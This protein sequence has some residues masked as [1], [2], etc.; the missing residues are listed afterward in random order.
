MLEACQKL[1]SSLTKELAGFGSAGVLAG[2][3]AR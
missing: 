1:A 3:L 2:V